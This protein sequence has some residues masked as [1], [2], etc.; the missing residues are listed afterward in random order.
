MNGS[1]RYIYK[2]KKWYGYSQGILLQKEIN[3]KKGGHSCRGQEEGLV[4]RGS[5]GVVA[6]VVADDLGRSKV[7]AESESMVYVPGTPYRR[8]R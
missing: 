6:R 7:A 2:G 8:L 3:C 4:A 1:F 5:V